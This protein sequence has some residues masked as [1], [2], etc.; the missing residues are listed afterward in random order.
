M[1]AKAR[2]AE[3]S[4]MIDGTNYKYIAQLAINASVEYCI[5][6]IKVLISSK[7]RPRERRR[8]LQADK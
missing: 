4:K 7:V 2:R 3:L 5:R 6:E 1:N 8:A